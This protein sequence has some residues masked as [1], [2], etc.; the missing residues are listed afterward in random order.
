VASSITT[1]SARA[2]VEALVAGE[3]DPRVLAELARGAG[4]KKLPDLAMARAG[5]FGAH[6]A[7]LARMHLEHIDHL[8]GMIGRLDG[9]I[10]QLIGPFASRWACCARSRDRR[11]HRPGAHRRDRHRHGSLCD[12]RPSGLLAG[13]YPG[14][15]ESAG[16]H[17]RAKTRTGN[18]EVREALVEA[19]WAAG[20]TGT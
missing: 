7:L 20:R 6:H 14:T 5:R 3:R 11:A 16:K 18:R 19:A 9:E 8:S 2:M 1:R 10:D 12:R 17:H 15:G 13:L 4:R